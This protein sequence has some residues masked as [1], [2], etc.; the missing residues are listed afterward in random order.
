DEELFAWAMDTLQSAVCSA[1]GD[2]SLPLE[3]TR[4]SRAR[5]YQMFATGPL[6]MLAELGASNGID[7]YQECESALPRIVGFTLRSIDDPRPIEAHADEQQQDIGELKGYR[8]AWLAP[9]LKRNP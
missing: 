1:G 9:W 5:E 3:M 6:V 2:G 4:G 7:T 8:V